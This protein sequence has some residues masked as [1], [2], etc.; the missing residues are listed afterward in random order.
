[1]SLWIAKSSAG[2]HGTNVQIFAGDVNGIRKMLHFIDE[3]SNGYS[4][5][6][7]QYI[8]RP[9]LYHKRKFDIRCWVLLILDGYKFYIHDEL[10]MRTSSLPYNR[11]SATANS[12]DAR[13]THITNHC[14]QS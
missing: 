2:C 8:D 5:V 3:Q 7:Q 1:M 9:L 6:V 10:V 13:L 11:D 14:I 12:H 4:W